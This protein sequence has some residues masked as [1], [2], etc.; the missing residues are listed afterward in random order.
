MRVVVV[1]AG[2]LGCAS[3]LELRRRGFDVEVVDRL[4]EAGHGTTSASCGIVRRFYSE[5]AMVALAEESALVWADWGAWLGP[6]DDD[7]AVFHRPGMLFLPAQLDAGILRIVQSMQEIGI[8]V[9]VLDQ[10]A[11]ATEF[12]Y[13]DQAAQFPPKLPSDEHFFEPTGRTLAGA[14]FEEDAGYVVSPGLATLNLRRAAEREGVRFLLNHRVLGV[15]LHGDGSF[16]IQTDR[17]RSLRC[18]AVVN[19]AGPHSRQINTL[20]GVSLPLETRA[21]RREVHALPNPFFSTEAGAGVP[22]VGDLDGGIYFRPEGNGHDLMV[23]STDP[24]GDPMEWI[25][26]P[27]T[28]DTGITEESRER[29]CLRLM[30]RFPDVVLG[31]RKG[32]ASLYDVTLQDWYPIVDRTDLP[33]FHV[34]MGTSGSSFKTAPLLGCLVAEQVVA[35]QQGRDIDAEPVQLDLPRLGRTLNTRFLSRKRPKLNTT[36]T[37]IG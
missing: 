33:G 16:E 15:E 24:H 3:A 28:F 36:S 17:D 25:D 9:R 37:V 35:W 34:C 4:G 30:K 26:D 20:A 19:V 14:V 21:L 23:G 29:Q 22:I 6:I 8:P 31:P 5:P 10:T 27:D 18:E 13:L 11:L 32:L 1:G 12:P 2:V 7:L